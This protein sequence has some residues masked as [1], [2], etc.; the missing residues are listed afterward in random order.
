VEGPS[1]EKDGGRFSVWGLAQE[2]EGGF[3]AKGE[4]VD[5]GTENVALCRWQ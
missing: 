4:K 1:A 2:S 3:S 5:R